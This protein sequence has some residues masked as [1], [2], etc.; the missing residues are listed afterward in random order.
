MIRIL[1]LIIFIFTSIAVFSQDIGENKNINE[2]S[3]TTPFRKGRWLTGLSGS[4]SSGSTKIDTASAKAF[5]NK[6]SFDFTTGKFFKDR[7]LLG[8]IFQ[9][10]RDNSRQFVDLESESLLLGPLLTYYL[11]NNP[12]G[13]IFLSMAP[14][15]AS[16]RERTVVIISGIPSQETLK[17]D[18]FGL[19]VQLGYSYV[20]HDRI[21]FDL[22][23]SLHGIWATAEREF[24]GS[25]TNT[26]LDINT[27]N[28]LFTFGFNV[29]L[30]EFFF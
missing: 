3:I 25:Q 16:F 6:Y 19:I 8:G 9:M 21:A 7:W 10:H 18:G 24:D 27:G 28:L 11:S 2:D 20:L 4:I 29:I 12:H 15:Y 22:G 14:G 30:G 17:G 13:S 1:I 5:T 23:L 26:K